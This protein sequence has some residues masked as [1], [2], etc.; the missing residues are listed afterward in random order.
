MGPILLWLTIPDLSLRN[1]GGTKV[2]AAIINGWG[3]GPGGLEWWEGTG[4]VLS[5]AEASKEG[6]G[7]EGDE[8]THLGE[9]SGKGRVILLA[10]KAHPPSKKHTGRIANVCVSGKGTGGLVHDA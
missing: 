6:D 1:V 10:Y 4:R 3:E 7:D 2:T 5:R 9:P 8:R